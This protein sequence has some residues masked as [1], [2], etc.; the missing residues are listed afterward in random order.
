[1]HAQDDD[2]DFEDDLTT[3]ATNVEQQG[4]ERN[5][6]GSNRA[7]NG[8]ELGT[9]QV[10]INEPSKQRVIVALAVL[11]AALAVLLGFLISIVV[12]QWLPRDKARD[13]SRLT[14]NPSA[15]DR[16]CRQT[17]KL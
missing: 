12:C 3:T 14:C 7:N 5:L 6:T 15:S 1:M 9:H 10:D 16:N 11:C 2:E 8:S 17:V 4:T 13:Q